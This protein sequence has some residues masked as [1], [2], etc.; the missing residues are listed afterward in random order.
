MKTVSMEKTFTITIS[1]V[2]IEE[3]TTEDLV[4]YCIR[5]VKRKQRAL[6]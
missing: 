1:N 4:A 3:L 2:T 5:N 6:E